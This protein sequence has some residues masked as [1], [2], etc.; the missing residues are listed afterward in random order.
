[1]EEVVEVH[2]AVAAVPHEGLDLEEVVGAH[3]AVVP[4]DLATTVDLQDQVDALT[5]MVKE[6][7]LEEM[8]IL[9]TP[10]TTLAQ[11]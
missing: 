2:Q 1:M 7:D 5:Q 11:D 3:Q 6:E 9:A 10:V 8:P 4:L